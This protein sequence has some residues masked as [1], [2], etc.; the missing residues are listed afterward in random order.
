MSKKPV[1]SERDVELPDWADDVTPADEVMKKFYAPTGTFKSGPIVGQ[2]AAAPAATETSAAHTSEEEKEESHAA[3]QEK[4]EQ[5]S[6]AI[7]TFPEQADTTT[8]LSSTNIAEKDD[9][10]E[11]AS[12]IPPDLKAQALS[13]EKATPGVLEASDAAKRPV[14]RITVTET[15]EGSQASPFEEFA[16]KWKRYLYPG[17]LAVMRTLFD[18]TIA[19]GTNECFTRYSELAGA[20]KMT[21]RNCINVMNSLVERGFVTRLEVRNDATSKGI[22]LRIHTDPLL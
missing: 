3:R 6:Q 21:R 16:R 8:A 12:P 17:Q 13:S 5:P 22:R 18:L 9:K 20:T 11:K 10:S 1:K 14:S 19:E 2:P 4:E 7:V 15:P